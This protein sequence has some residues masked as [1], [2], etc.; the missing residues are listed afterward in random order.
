MAAR[1]DIAFYSKAANSVG[2]LTRLAFRSFSRSLEA[3]TLPRGV[4]SGQW[5]FLRALWQ[6]EGIT[7]RELSRRVG[8]REPTTVTALRGME[9]AGLVA[10]VPSTE[11][12]RR[13]HVF[14]TPRARTLEAELMPCVVAVNKAAL[15]GM[16]ADEVRTL[17]R[18]LAQV[19]AN[20]AES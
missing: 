17:R 7:Q 13:V 12:R 16:T 19:T 10:R 8:M 20:L 4:S 6:E 11:D 18:L 1:S 14:L 2:Y 5:R 3:L 15:K 9:Q